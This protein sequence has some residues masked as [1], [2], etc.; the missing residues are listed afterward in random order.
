MVTFVLDSSAVLRFL[1]DEAGAER[2]EQIFLDAS[3]GDCSV[4]ISA[5][6]WGEVVGVTAKRQGRTKAEALLTRLGRYGLEVIPVTAERAS[7]SAFLKLSRGLSYADAFCVELA[8]DSPGA[9]LVTADFGMKVAEQ[10]VRIE[11]L[12][13]KPRA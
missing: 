5:I 8:T 13:T 12:P 1:E 10:D 2:V 9:V 11:F 6:N 4:E 7:R 3:I